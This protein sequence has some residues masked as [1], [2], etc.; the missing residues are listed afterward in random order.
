MPYATNQGIR[1]H[2]E[3]EGAGPPLVLQHGFSSSM[4]R[5]YDDGYVD[6]LKP[7][8]QLM[9]LPRFDGQFC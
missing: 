9:G 2:Y 7:D 1:I 4:A 5:W 8:Y 6:A 3:V